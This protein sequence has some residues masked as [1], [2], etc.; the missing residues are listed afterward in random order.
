MSKKKKE[1]KSGKLFIVILSILII[2]VVVLTILLLSK[3]SFWKNT[4]SVNIGQNKN[5]NG[6]TISGMTQAEAYT[7]LDNYIKQKS[8]NFSLILKH[9]DKIYT[10]NNQD[11]TI[12]DDLH[13]IIDIAK[14]TKNP[15]LEELNYFVEHGNSTMVSFNYIFQGL[16]EKI[17][18]I[19]QEIEIEPINSEITFHPDSKEMFEITEEQSGKKVDRAKLYDKINEQ[20]QKT[21]SILV[22]LELEDAPAEITKEDNEK[23]TTLIS[24]FSTN[25][26]DST[27]SRK[28]NVKLALSKFN[29]MKIN[30][31]ES[32]SFNE[33]T[34]P[35][36]QD[37]GYKIA[38]IILNGRFTDGVGGGICQASTTLYNALVLGGIRIDEVHKHTL[39][40]RYVP[41]ALDAMVS[42]GLSDMRF[43]NNLDY[44]IFIKTSS[45]SDKV[46][47]EIY[48]MRQDVTYK[49]RSETVEV[50]K[51]LPDEI[52][53]DT[54]GEYTDKVL[55]KGETYRLSYSKEGY[56]VNSY[57]QVWQNGIMLSENLLRHE[58][59]KPQAGIIIEGVYE[60]I[61]SVPIIEDTNTDSSDTNF[62]FSN[63]SSQLCP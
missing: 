8:E 41:L 30:P 19:C 2:A 5:I 1:N 43:T 39:P 32:I 49:T 50:L 34:G 36:T 3:L 31:G 42:E 45:T 38:T 25:V 12:N 51:A 26:S 15:E 46:S 40:V 6:L 28:H 17:D 20:F 47:V 33:V 44:P 48:S 16:T 53:P 58:I 52:V 10:L 62:L 24:S 29:G 22:D 59:Y 35:H 7:A 23:L 61:E 4:N 63:S 55:F 56:D 14:G 60:P 54:K 21:N 13:T 11:Y 27:G 57:I 9:D 18:K 37:A